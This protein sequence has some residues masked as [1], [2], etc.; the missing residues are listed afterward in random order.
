MDIYSMHRIFFR[1]DNDSIE[2]LVG[3]WLKTNVI[4]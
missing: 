2:I 4:L 1:E 3:Y